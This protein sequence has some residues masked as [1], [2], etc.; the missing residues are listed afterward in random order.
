MGL[1]NDDDDAREE[2]INIWCQTVRSRND[3]KDAFKRCVRT[4]EKYRLYAEDAD[5]IDTEPLILW[6]EQFLPDNEYSNDIK[7]NL[8]N[9]RLFGW[10]LLLDIDDYHQMRNDPLYQGWDNDEEEN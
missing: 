5:C 7:H 6:A 3:A 9:Q 4:K 10:N 8:Y 1:Y 2:A